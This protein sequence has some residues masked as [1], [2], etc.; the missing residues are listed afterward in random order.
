MG[1]RTYRPEF[2]WRWNTFIGAQLFGCSKRYLGQAGLTFIGHS[3][4]RQRGRR[5]ILYVLSCNKVVLS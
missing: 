3:G 2:K 4:D 5:G 1:Q